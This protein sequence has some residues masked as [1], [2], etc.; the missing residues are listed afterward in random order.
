[1]TFITDNNKLT[2]EERLTLIDAIARTRDLPKAKREFVK[3]FPSSA[4]IL[5]ST[6][7]VQFALNYPDEIKELRHKYDGTIDD[8]P[9]S[10]YRQQLMFL[11]EIR[12]AAMELRTVGVGANGDPIEKRELA[13]ANRAVENMFKL[14]QAWD[15]LKIKERELN[16]D[17]SSHFGEQSGPTV[18]VA[19]MHTKEPDPLL[20]DDYGQTD[21]ADM[22]MASE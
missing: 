6:F 13:V 18:Q 17:D 2:D 7:L 1:M 14:R 22:G 21:A 12:E 11:E 20:G 5:S 16:R 4:P 9:G 19:V 3:A 8:L 15:T 10:S